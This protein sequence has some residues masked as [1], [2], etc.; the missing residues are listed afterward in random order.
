MLL[1]YLALAAL[2]G[3][4]L[5]GMAPQSLTLEEV[6]TKIDQ[7]GSTLKSMSSSIN[8]KKWTDILE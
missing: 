6:L 1:A 3:N 4:L 7:R 2:I 8:Q 5:P